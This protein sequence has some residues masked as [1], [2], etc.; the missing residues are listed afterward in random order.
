[1]GKIIL[2]IAAAGALAW[3]GAAWAVLQSD[4]NTLD[5]GQ[6]IPGATVKL[7]RST[8][9]KVQATKTETQPTPEPTP[10]TTVLTPTPQETVTPPPETPKGNEMPSQ[11]EPSTPVPEP[12]DIGSTQ[13]PPVV[14]PGVL[15]QSEQVKEKTGSPRQMRSQ[16]ELTTPEKKHKTAVRRAK[17]RKQAEPGFQK[18]VEKPSQTGMGPTREPAHRPAS[19]DVVKSLK[20]QDVGGVRRNP[21]VKGPTTSSTRAKVSGRP[22]TTRPQGGQIHEKRGQK[23]TTGQKEMKPQK[24]PATGGRA[25]R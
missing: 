21:E 1:M 18:T 23:K 4:T 22:G 5:N 3:A 17:S 8:P 9:R 12:R 6:Q 15:P 24:V 13:P 11:G 16:D 10:Q 20:S 14:V 25:H 19:T 7:P 2:S